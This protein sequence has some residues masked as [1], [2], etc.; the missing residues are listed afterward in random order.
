[1]PIVLLALILSLTTAEV[2][3]AQSLSDY[4]CRIER[5]QAAP[6]LPGPSKE[7]LESTYL[8]KEF[9]VDRRSGITVGAV[10]NNMVVAPIVLDLG[11]KAGAYKVVALMP[12]EKGGGASSNVYTLVVNE[13]ESGQS[14]PFAYMHNATVYF[15]KCV[16]F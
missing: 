5:I 13:F 14:K 8:G 7:F 3:A 12:R 6:D 16:H 1:M 2:A 9:T 11:D 10:K 4:R 15:G